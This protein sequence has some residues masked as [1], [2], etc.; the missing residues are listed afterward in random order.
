MPIVTLEV[1]SLNG[2]VCSVRCNESW[3]G[4]QLKEAIENATC[5]GFLACD[6]RLALGGRI[7]RDDDLLGEDVPENGVLSVILEPLPERASLREVIYRKV[8]KR[9]W[10][11]AF[12]VNDF[13]RLLANKRG[14]LRLGHE[15]EHWSEQ[16]TARWHFWNLLMVHPTALSDRPTKRFSLEMQRLE[17]KHRRLFGWGPAVFCFSCE[18]SESSMSLS[19][20]ARACREHLNQADLS[21][22]R[23]SWKSARW[24]VEDAAR[25]TLLC[26]VIETGPEALPALLEE[27]WAE[28]HTLRWILEEKRE[29]SQP[30]VKP[31]SFLRKYLVKEFQDML[32]PSLSVWTS[33]P[34]QI[35]APSAVWCNFRVRQFQIQS[36]VRASLGTL[37]GNRSLSRKSIW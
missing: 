23:E 21:A 35:P 27:H 28:F 19:R 30:P 22:E 10:K 6:Q 9:R 34:T 12:D 4:W 20:C 14:L 1:H 17:E 2:P 16:D 8:A 3:S 25:L 11:H 18:E 33:A 31:A 37:L 5:G 32:S 13:E 24:T 7:V 15:S 29:W 26:L 36:N